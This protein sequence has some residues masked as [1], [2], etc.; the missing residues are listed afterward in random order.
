MIES[1]QIVFIHEYLTSFFEHSEDPVSPSGVKDM[2]L[3]ESAI[4]RPFM[5]SGGNDLYVG[6]F[7]KAAAL[8][9]S[10]IN[11]H[12]FYNGNKRTALLSAMV[13]LG[14]NGWW[15][16]L[17]ATTDDELFEFTRQAAAHELTPNRDDEL[18]IIAEWFK[19]N[20]RR[21]ESGEHQ[22]TFRDLKEILTGFGFDVVESSDNL[23]EV[24]K[25]DIVKTKILRKGSKGKENYD[26]KYIGDLRRRLKLTNAYGVDS[27]EFYG[28]RGF[29]ATL[30]IFMKLREKV[31][32]KL[33]KI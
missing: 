20:S 23:I 3:L 18:R 15:L 30:S 7:T 13:Y 29:D 10:I 21:R 27:Y 14:D 6:V 4:S 26:K 28:Q 9:H 2:G 22:L 25:D 16:T 11:N 5:T 12:C 32:R 31:M 24:R 8:F 33:A 1:R 19:Y 17:A